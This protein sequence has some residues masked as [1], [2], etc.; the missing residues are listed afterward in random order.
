MPKDSGEPAVEELLPVDML[1]AEVCSSDDDVDDTR[2]GG[3]VPVPVVREECFLRLGM[4]IDSDM[5][6]CV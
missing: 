1:K 4:A 6:M 5:L 2:L 3:V